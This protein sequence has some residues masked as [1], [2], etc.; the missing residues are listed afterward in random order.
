MALYVNGRVFGG[1]PWIDIT[2]T[3][4]AGSTSITLS[5]S[6]ITTSSTIDIYTDADVDYNSVSVSTGSVTITFDEQQS[7]MGVKVRVS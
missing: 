6:S 1:A 2:G 7:D 5:D 4:T 3:L